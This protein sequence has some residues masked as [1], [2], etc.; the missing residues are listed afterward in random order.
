[1]GEIW[2][3]AGL[4]S[5]EF[6][7]SAR[8]GLER[9]RDS[10]S[11]FTARELGPGTVDVALL[12]LAKVP[13]LSGDPESVVLASYV[14]FDGDFEGQL[15]MLFRPD[16]AEEL[17]A[18]LAPG[19]LDGL[20]AHDFPALLES[21]LLELANVV[22][23]AVLNAFADGVGVR[24]CPT[25]PILARDM[26]GAI[27]GSTMAYADVSDAVYVVHIKFTLALG[28]ASFEIVF[29]PRACSN[30][31]VFLGDGIGLCLQT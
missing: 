20:P 23:S 31:P 5:R 8:I 4:S 19:I 25:P 24:L 3:W 13:L 10:L 9:A 18:F 6:A 22:G 29:L 27:L 15:I 17:A 28:G 1:M 30:L 7:E 11:A 26:A 12:D 16:T 2:R 14:R 21:L